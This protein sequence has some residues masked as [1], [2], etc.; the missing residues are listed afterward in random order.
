M[1]ML[2]L[3]GVT[4]RFG[5]LV[6][7]NSLSFSVAE[8]SIHGL[9]GPN[10]AGK[11]TVFNAV[12]RFRKQDAGTIAFKGRRLDCEAHEVVKRGIGRTFQNVEL[13]RGQTVLDN[14]MI[15]LH[16]S[17]RADF[18]SAALRT[19]AALREE[20]ELRQK[21]T[22]VLES[23]GIPGYAGRLAHG[24]PYG[25]QKLVELARAMVLRPSLILLDEPVAGM[26]PTERR[27]LA[28]VIRMI[29]DSYNMTVLLVEHDMSFVMGLCD[30]ITVMNF[31]SK[32]AEGTP[33]EVQRNPQVIQAYLGEED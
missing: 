3:D 33:D 24:L 4:V 5:G 6:A 32:I 29:R 14:I 21:A 22:E 12:S 18:L 31:G 26:N 28:Q 8:G 16:T 20:A 10:G 23:L 17:S 1:E 2:Q 30:K 7:V 27:E 11:S 13:F 19:P 25:V 9:I 15:G